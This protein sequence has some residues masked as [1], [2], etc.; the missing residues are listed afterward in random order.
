MKPNRRPPAL[1]FAFCLAFAFLNLN[2]ASAE[3]QA[4]QVQVTAAV[5]SS[6]AQGTINLNVKVTGKGFKN[7]AQA[8]WFI[9][10]TTNP[11]GVTV[12]STTFISSTE[13]T[14]NITVD[15]T[16][17]IANFDI[18]VLNSDGRGGKGTELFAVLAKG[19]GNAACPAMQPAPTGDTKCYAALP[20]CLDTSFGGVG[21]V[22]TDAAPGYVSS[23]DEAD[24]VAVQL[25][26]KVVVAG[27]TRIS[28]TDFDFTVIRY[29]VDGS[30]DTSFGDLDPLNP[31]LRRGYTVTSITTGFDYAYAL[32]LQPDG[33]ILVTGAADGGNDSV[34]VRYKSDGTLDSTFA[35]GGIV[36]L[37][38]APR[39]D[40]ALQADGKIVVGGAAASGG[41]GLIRL[42]PNG[43]LDSG[44]DSDGVVTASASGA[45]R[46]SS[47]GMGLSIQRVPAVT[48]E[49]RI[50]L[51]GWSKLSSSP[52]ATY[53]QEWTMM[54]FRSNGATDTSFGSSGIVKTYFYGFGDQ[55]RRV[56][57]DSSNRI[58]VA[59]TIRSSSDSCG[60][61]II[62]SAV[63][64]YAQDGSLDGS[65]TGGKQ[66][67]DVY[68][69]SDTY[70][71]LS[72]QPDGKILISEVARSSDNTVNHFGLV[73]FNI[74]GTRDSSFGLLGNGVVTTDLY[75]TESW[76][77]GGVA[78]QPTDGKIV[79]AGGAYL[80]PGNTQ[81]EIVVARYFP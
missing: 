5:P 2:G 54:R 20:G 7:G 55:A 17:T 8:K 1:F 73:R 56:R 45:K 63:V 61:Y 32:V 46:G 53:N 9:T 25:D 28:S 81:A 16:A 78:L 31:G 49:E 30:L 40:I 69:G 33:K 77:F 35:G 52:S 12:N 70:T 21:Y 27:R 76:A 14:A 19:G 43:S 38:I 13:V 80:G 59:G 71:G 44:F 29:N 48:G 50:V 39:S 23:G 26:G 34:V 10:G 47:A 64:R 15:D 6:T 57:I 79:I 74:D 42:N 65:F 3:V 62:D 58:V 41:F 68:G 60:S 66:I 72:L 18:Q 24:G 36:H 11:G 4:Q 67:V 75:G 51:V 37:G 22:H